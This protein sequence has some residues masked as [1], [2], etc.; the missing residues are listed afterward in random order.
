MEP[1][2][3]E[4]AQH[5]KRILHELLH[6][7]LLS[8]YACIE[9]LKPTSRVGLSQWSSPPQKLFEIRSSPSSQS[10]N[11]QPLSKASCSW[12]EL[13]SRGTIRDDADAAPCSLKCQRSYFLPF[14]SSFNNK[15]ANSTP[16]PLAG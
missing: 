5:K 1:P 11:P 2:Q 14:N 8:M 9:A 4:L 3:H 7:D 16:V 13:I 15:E 12:V 10:R 6:V